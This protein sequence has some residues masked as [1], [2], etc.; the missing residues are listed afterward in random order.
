MENENTT[1]KKLN[2][3]TVS[4]IIYGILFFGLIL[5]SALPI[6][7]LNIAVKALLVICACRIYR[8]RNHRTVAVLASVLLPA[9]FL[10]IAA[11]VAIGGTLFA[12]NVQ[13]KI[14]FA[15][16]T[17]ATAIVLITLIDIS[18]L[19]YALSTVIPA[20]T[21]GICISRKVDRLTSICTVSA[22]FAVII[23]VPILIWAND[24]GFLASFDAFSSGIKEALAEIFKTYTDAFLKVAAENQMAVDLSAITELEKLSDELIGAILLIAPALVIVYTNVSAFLANLLSNDLRLSSGETLEQKE[25][26]FYPSSPSAW[27]F[28]IS[29]ILS[30]FSLG[31][32]RTMEILSVTMLNLNIILMPAFFYVGIKT[33][34]IFPSRR[35]SIALTIMIVLLLI[36]FGAIVIY[37]LA[38]IGAFNTIKRNRFTHK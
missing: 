33:F 7:E 2:K 5:Y 6:Y 10:V 30:F 19:P 14:I 32:S 37:P 11:S 12:K 36:Y 25:M 26:D 20:I 35:S 1:S 4:L 13:G 31:S 16:S 9:E 24:Q 27:I 3:K 22:S 15:I 29:I 18:V 34:K 38:A 23:A 21:L 17:V 28:V 8:S